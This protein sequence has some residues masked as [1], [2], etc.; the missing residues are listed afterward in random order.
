MHRSVVLALALVALSGI[1]HAGEEPTTIRVTEEASVTSRPDRA[2]IEIA[3]VTR[4][5]SAADAATANAEQVQRVLAALRKALGRDA[6]LET[7]SYSLQPD[8]QYPQNGAPKLVGFTATNLVEVT[9][10][11]VSLVGTAIDEAAAAGANQIQGVRFTLQND[12]SAQRR[13]L[14]AAARKARTSASA[15]AEALDLEVVR[16]VSI[17][18][19][20]PETPRP[21][22]EAALAR[23]DTPVIPGELE[24]TATV[25]LTLEVRPRTARAA[26]SR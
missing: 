14:Q 15:L 22:H 6:K 2:E 24:T 19:T 13:A 3:V 23:R 4:S 8:Y 26:A 16:I 11:D 21:I 7:R 18:E 25:S 5:A 9:L 1:A 10:D 17:V 12:A 20:T